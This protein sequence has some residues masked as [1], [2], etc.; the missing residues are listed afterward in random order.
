MQ[1]GTIEGK[2]ES[3][4][5]PFCLRKRRIDLSFAE[6]KVDSF[7]LWRVAFKNGNRG[8]GGEKG[9]SVR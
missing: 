6:M 3:K 5:L 9:K 2:I 7:P 1:E 4:Q 8:G